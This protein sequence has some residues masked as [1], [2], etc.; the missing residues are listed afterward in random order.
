[1]Q[2]KIL[3]LLKT[4]NRAF[5]VDEINDAL[6]FKTVDELKELLKTLNDM[7]DNLKVYRTKH[8]GYMLFNNSHLK[9]G[10]MQTNKKG[11]G[12]VD[13][14]GDEDV[15]IAPTNINGAIHGDKVIVEITS[16]KGIDLE[17][18]ILKIVDRK[19]KQ[20]VGEVYYRNNMPYLKI[21]DE[22]VKLN[23]EIDKNKTMNAMPGHKVLVKITNKVKDN[24]Y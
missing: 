11:F 7:E 6:G 18:R 15:F 5:S 23:I 24:T 12:F 8:D 9:I 21:D 3:E 1:M 22:R 4:E 14:E 20:M 13:I 19:F 16:P 10:V 17:G 2:D